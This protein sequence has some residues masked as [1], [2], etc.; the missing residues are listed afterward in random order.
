MEIKIEKDIPLPPER[1]SRYPWNAM[2]VGDSFFVDNEVQG[3]KLRGAA[4]AASKRLKKKFAVRRVTG[5]YRCWRI[6]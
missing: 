5:G 4:N 6:G 1:R 2:Q 3:R